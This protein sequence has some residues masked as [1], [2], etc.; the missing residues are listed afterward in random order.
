MIIRSAADNLAGRSIDHGDQIQPP[1]PVRIYVILSP[2]F[3]PGAKALKSRF[4]RA[5]IKPVVPLL[6]GRCP[7]RPGR[8]GHQAQLTHQIA[9][10]LLAGEDA[11]RASWA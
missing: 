5:G 6:G 1:F 10:Q 3:S 8:A 7:P 9:D 2:I 11:Q 4:T